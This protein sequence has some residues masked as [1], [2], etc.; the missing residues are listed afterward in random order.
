MEEDIGLEEDNYL[1]VEDYRYFDSHNLEAVEGD[2]LDD[3]VLDNYW[4]M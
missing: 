1:V 3:V 4:D 2:N